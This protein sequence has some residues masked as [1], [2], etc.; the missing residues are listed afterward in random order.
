MTDSAQSGTETETQRLR[1]AVL[2]VGPRAR[3]LVSSLQ[4]FD[5][6]VTQ[7]PPDSAAPGR[8]ETDGILLATPTS[9]HI[10]R[11]EEAMAH[12]VPVFCPSPLSRTAEEARRLINSAR[13]AD[14]LLGVDVSFRACEAMRVL[15]STVQAGE[16]GDI[17]AIDLTYHSAHPADER[18]KTDPAQSGGGCVIDLGTPLID[19]ALW[20][21]G[22]PR[23]TEVSS[24]LYANGE[25]TDTMADR[26]SAPAEEY[27]TSRLELDTGATVNFACSWQLPLGA[28][29]RIEVTFYG[30]EGGGT[31]RNVGPS[32]SSFES[33]VF[34][35]THRH[36]L[37]QSGSEWIDKAAPAW[38]AALA[39]GAGYDPW[40]EGVIDVAATIDRILQRDH[41]PH[42]T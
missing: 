20:T 24:R 6:T 14:L 31:F 15:R 4:A 27:A 13:A 9:L 8:D 37:A 12:G 7:H 35:G 26:T 29:A 23:V 36:P 41:A 38:A 2:G 10:E 22:F 33:A 25:R 32:L 11:A 39:R 5:A 1:L 34:R 18:W 42:P 30:T 21:L 3:G 28:D 16:L 17:Y 40:V 19:V